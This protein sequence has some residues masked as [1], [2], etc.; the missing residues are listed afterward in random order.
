MKKE[1]SD[2]TIKTIAASF[3]KQAQKYGFTLND[4]LRFTNYL[5]DEAM[6][7][8]SL[9][10]E[11]KETTI[12]LQGSIKKLPLETERLIIR[13]TTKKDLSIIK[14]WLEDKEG[15]FF[16]L[17]R[18]DNQQETID[19]VFENENNLLGTICLKDKT[20]IGLIA[21][22]NIDEYHRKAELRKMIGVTK[23]RGKGYGNE[24]TKAWIEYGFFTLNLEKI[25]LTTINTDI[26]NIR[27]NEALGFRVEG[28][29]RNELKIDG[30]YYDVLQMSLLKEWVINK[31]SQK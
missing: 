31:E 14:S 5:L 17:S 25:Y 10:T 3:I 11:K 24:A 27:I 20:P 26:K 8:L 12:Y 7:A 30:E 16:L 19:E 23:E 13:Q 22:L 1:I 9:N 6:Q 28:L 18:L 15:R 2:E 21:Y 4:Y 29:L